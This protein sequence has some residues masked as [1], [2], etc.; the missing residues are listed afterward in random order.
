M[1]TAS[2]YYFDHPTLDQEVKMKHTLQTEFDHVL[3]SGWRPP[4]QSRR[5]LLVWS[6]NHYTNHLKDEGRLAEDAFTCEDNYATL[7]KTFGPNYEAL[8][9]KVGYIKGIFD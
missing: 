5:D 9:S 1:L 3:P 7:L 4:L 6:C 2:A 8:K